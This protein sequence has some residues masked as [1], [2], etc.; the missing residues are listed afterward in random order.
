MKDNYENSRFGA[1]ST[2]A[3]LMRTEDTIN[4]ARAVREDA[5]RAEDKAVRERLEK[6]SAS[7]GEHLSLVDMLNR[8]SVTRAPMETGID[9]ITKI[10]EQQKLGYRTP[11]QH[12]RE[13]AKFEKAAGGLDQSFNNSIH[14][15]SFVALIRWQK[16]MDLQADMTRGLNRQNRLALKDP[17]FREEHD[18]E[19]LPSY[20]CRLTK[21]K[22]SFSVPGCWPW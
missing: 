11:A 17:L 22:W 3:Q 8:M 10:R 5:E 21:T 12:N 14:K 2:H 20:V 15:A 13:H 6:M 1:E 4:K 19:G 7:S 9:A 16:L 18:C